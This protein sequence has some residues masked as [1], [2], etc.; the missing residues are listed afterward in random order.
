M[1]AVVVERVGIGKI[2]GD[3]VDDIE[4]LDEG[5]LVD[6][7]SVGGTVVEQVGLRAGVAEGIDVNLTVGFNVVGFSVGGTDAGMV[8]LDIGFTVGFH[9]VG[10][11]V[12]ATV[13]SQVGLRVGVADGVDVD[14]AV[15]FKLLGF[16][17]G[18]TVFDRV[19]L[20]VGPGL[21]AT[22]GRNVGFG[23]GVP[24]GV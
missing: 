5:T 3:T 12:G 24:V 11:S 16:S 10:F 17:V 9:V 19:G 13:V 8:E 7:D 4:G 21:G 6:G 14:F 20:A 1:G 22:D 18:G 23:T 15:G 2:V